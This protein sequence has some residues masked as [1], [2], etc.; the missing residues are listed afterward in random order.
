MLPAT[1]ACCARKKNKQKALLQNEQ[2][3]TF[4]NWMY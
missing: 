3:M 2:S 4:A 1:Q